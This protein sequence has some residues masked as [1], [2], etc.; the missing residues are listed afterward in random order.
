M[1]FAYQDMVYSFVEVDRN[2]LL[3][4]RIYKYLDARLILKIEG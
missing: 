4:Q 2:I 1:N 3:A